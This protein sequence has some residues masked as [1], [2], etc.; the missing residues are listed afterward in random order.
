MVCW[1]TI[2]SVLVDAT[3]RQWRNV[4]TIDAASTA[5]AVP[6]AICQKGFVSDIVVIALIA[7]ALQAQL[8]W[9]AAR[10]YRQEADAA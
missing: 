2:F 1:L 9:L 7:F 4:P 3:I 10:S 5:D 6:V 8:F